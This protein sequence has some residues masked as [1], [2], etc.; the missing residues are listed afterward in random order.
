MC[1]P[2]QPSMTGRRVDWDVSARHQA[3]SRRTFCSLS[4]SVVLTRAPLR[5]MVRTTCR[6]VHSC[7]GRTAPDHC[8][9]LPLQPLHAEAYLCARQ[10]WVEVIMC[11]DIYQEPRASWYVSG[12]HHSWGIQAY[13]HAAMV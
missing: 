9:H 12:V 6:S 7:M 4:V 5:S 2:V 3:V 13:T 8:F 10:G 11:E 1:L